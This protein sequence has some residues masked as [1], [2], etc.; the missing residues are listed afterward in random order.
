MVVKNYDMK[1]IVEKTYINL[2]I[3]VYR[4]GSRTLFSSL[5]HVHRQHVNKI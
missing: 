3:K 1:N 4:D 2:E 5:I